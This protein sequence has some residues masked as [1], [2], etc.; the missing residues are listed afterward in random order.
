[1]TTATAI[2][3]CQLRRKMRSTATTSRRAHG[4][5]LGDGVHRVL[6]EIRAVIVGPDLYA[7]R[8]AQAEPVDLLLQVD[9]DFGGVLALDHLHDALDDLVAVVE[10]NDAGSRPRADP[11]GAQVAHDD[12][13]AAATRDDDPRNVIQ[14]FEQPDTAYDERL[15][16]A[17]QDAA[18][19]V[20]AVRAQ[21]RRHLIDRDAVFAKQR[22][23]QP[24]LIFLDRAAEAH[25]VRDTADPA[26]RGTDD[27]VLNRAH[28]VQGHVGW[29]FDDVAIDLSD[30]IGERRE[31]RA[32]RR[33]PG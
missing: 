21:R 29:R 30:R 32:A 24:R 18:A 5:V 26:Q 4:K 7:L 33:A 2:A 6:N 12:R 14:V 13:P 31:R 11:H 27:P 9:H 25:D 1:M 19:G 28:F 17:G 8:Q 16:P 20:R 3:A 23:I 15:F 22:G 10:C